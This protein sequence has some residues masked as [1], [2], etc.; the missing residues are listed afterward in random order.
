MTIRE[1]AYELYKIDWKDQHKITPEIEMYC[2]EDY[3]EGLVDNHT[4]YTYEDYLMNFGYYGE[5][6]VCFDEFLDNEYQDK[7]YMEELFDDKTLY[8]EY[9]DDICE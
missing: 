7:E 3:Y 5:L 9:L 6:Y 2:L 8:K 4:N 1:L